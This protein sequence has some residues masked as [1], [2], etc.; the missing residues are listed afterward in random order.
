MRKTMT[1]PV[2]ATKTPKNQPEPFRESLVLAAPARPMFAPLSRPSLKSLI[3][4]IWALATIAAGVGI[5]RLI[6]QSRPA[7]ITEPPAPIAEATIQPAAAHTTA[8]GL[9]ATP[10]QP[11]LTVRPASSVQQAQ[12]GSPAAVMSTSALQATSNPDSLQPGFASEVHIQGQI[13][14]S[15]SL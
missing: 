2:K 8:I 5:G 14:T 7:A 6:V 1:N 11:S 4:I 9:A 15:P 3:W 13:G 10:A 12:A